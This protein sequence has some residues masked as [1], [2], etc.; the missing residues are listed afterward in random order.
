MATHIPGIRKLSS[1]LLLNVLHDIYLLAC[2]ERG[3]K[4]VNG[5]ECSGNCSHV[6]VPAFNQNTKAEQVM[7]LTALIS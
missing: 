4:I 7:R 5:M 1:L 3:G 6:T 2:K